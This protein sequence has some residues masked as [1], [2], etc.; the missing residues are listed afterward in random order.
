MMTRELAL[1]LRDAGVEWAPAKGDR[2]VVF[3][4]D[5]DTDVF[6]VSDMVIEVLDVPQGRQVLA[7]NGTTEWALDSFEAE[8]A[9]WVPRED[10]LRDLL[11]EA[12]V[13]L[14]R[15][16]GAADGFAVTVRR[17]AGLE[18]HVDVDAESAYARAVLAVLDG[19]AR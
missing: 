5:F 7:F 15:L 18:R 1:A 10:Q 14:E 16:D 12:F 2:F 13:S 6:V 4:R 19:S 17:G 9:V 8:V 11:G 3:D